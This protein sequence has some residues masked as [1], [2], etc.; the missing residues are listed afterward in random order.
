[1]SKTVVLLSGGL[2]SSVLLYSLLR[3]RRECIALSVLYGQRHRAELAAAGMIVRE[4]KVEYRVCEADDALSEVFEGAKSSQ[5]GRIEDVPEGHYA[6]PNMAVTIVPNRN[7]ILLAI[8]GACAVST[9]AESIAY[10]AHAGDHP[11]YPDCRPEFIESCA[12]TLQLGSGIR[13][14]A[15]FQNTS[16]A[17]IVKIGAECHVPFGMTYS[18]YKGGTRH[19]G[20][21]S[22]CVE[23]REAF[24]I[25]GVNDPTRYIDETDFW[26]K[27]VAKR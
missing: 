11:V 8:A 1:M 7:M 17:G 19:C 13:L 3:E 18:C 23:R 16:K 22:T 26:R 10:A 9:G 24:D 14:E 25:A 5:V 15:P 12:E 20:R 21:C 2:D 4:T 6:E 27:A